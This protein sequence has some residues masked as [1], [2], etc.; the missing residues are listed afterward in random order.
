[1]PLLYLLTSPSCEDEPI[2]VMICQKTKK[3]KKNYFCTFRN[4]L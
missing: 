1:M 3:K 4:R 2:L